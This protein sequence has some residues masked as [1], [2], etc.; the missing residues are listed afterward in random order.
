MPDGGLS[1]RTARR[2]KS[3][4][5]DWAEGDTRVNVTFLVKDEVKS[6]I[7]LEHRRL[8][9]ASEAERMKVYWRRRLQALK[10]ALEQ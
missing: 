5:F 1:P 7:A 6:T 9:N 2:P 3:A 10:E 8:P 4:R